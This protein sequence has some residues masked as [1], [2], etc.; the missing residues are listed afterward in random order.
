[1]N[2]V[3]SSQQRCEILGKFITIYIY[4]YRVK[5]SIYCCYAPVELHEHPRHYHIS[6]QFLYNFF[7]IFF[8][9]LT[10]TFSLTFLPPLPFHLPITLYF[11]ITLH[12]SLHLPLFCLFLFH[13]FTI[14]FS[15][16]YIFISPLPSILIALL[17]IFPF[18]FPYFVSSYSHHFTINL[19]FFLPSFA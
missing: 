3:S 9:F 2:R 19:S 11:N 17:F 14:P 4:I 10:F 18:I 13:P 1:M 5:H 16:S 8:F 15:L 7:N 6:F 12:F